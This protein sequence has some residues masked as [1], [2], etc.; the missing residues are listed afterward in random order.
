MIVII[1]IE[2]IQFISINELVLVSKIENKF[3]I[4]ITY[5]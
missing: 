3:V 1:V 4:I 2:E 5:N